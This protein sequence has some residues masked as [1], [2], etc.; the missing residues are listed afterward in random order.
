MDLPG[1]GY[2]KVAESIKLQWQGFMAD[3]LARRECLCGLILLMD[4][5]H[6]LTDYDRNLLDWNAEH[7]IPTHILL[8]KTDKLKRGPSLDRLRQVERMLEQWPS[9]VSVQLFSALKRQGIDP[10]HRVLDRWLEVPEP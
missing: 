7:G 6:P 10:A 8:T 9:G 1:Y 2:A 3:Y 5:R 4:I